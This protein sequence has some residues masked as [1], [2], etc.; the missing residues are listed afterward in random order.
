MPIYI[1]QYNSAIIS[2]KLQLKTT[3]YHFCAFFCKKNVL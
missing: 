2:I 3:I 1:W